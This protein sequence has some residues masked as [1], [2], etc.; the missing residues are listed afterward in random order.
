MESVRNRPLRALRA[1]REL[2]RDPDDLPKVFEIVD[3]IPGRS[4]R[5]VLARMRAT[6]SGRRILVTRPNLSARLADRAALFALP[7]G[8]LGH[9]YAAFAERAGITPQGIVDAS[10]AG[11]ID[12][13]DEPEDLRF[14]GERLRDSHDL[15]HVVTG[16]GTDVAGEVALLAFSYAQ[17]RHPGIA[18][19]C[20]FAYLHFLPPL[21]E[22]MRDAHRRGK[23]AAWLPAVVWED[24]LARPLAEVREALGVG[25]APAYTPIPTEVLRGATLLD[26]IR[27]RNAYLAGAA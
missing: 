25:P 18:A 13:P 15:W 10:L 14:S 12:D 3:S 7:A 6:E 27:A 17:T 21:N 24:L 26:R 4:P 20:G 5:R 16:Y 22:L 8:T 9:E 19:I 23:A 1:L 11:S 2:A